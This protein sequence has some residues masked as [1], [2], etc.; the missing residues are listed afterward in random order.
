MASTQ[1]AI[2][3]EWLP[4]ARQ[5]D[6]EAFSVLVEFYL[7]KVY[8][9]CL[10]LL[11]QREDA[12]DCVQETFVKA[13]HSLQ[14]FKSHA[15]FYTWI[16]RIAVNT[17]LDL[18][19][20]NSRKMTLSLDEANENSEVSLRDRIRDERP[21]PDEVLEGKEF[22]DRIRSS[23]A[24]LPEMMQEILVLR[25]LQECSYQEI[26]ALLGIAQGTVKSR[27]YRARR[28]LMNILQDTEQSQ[29]PERQSN[30]V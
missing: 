23:L 15:S 28:Q 26:A 25:D 10:S 27:L 17:C 22:S 19:R 24:V 4:L 7:P 11:G 3:S 16:Y 6:E 8:G 13:W 20:S 29:E 14:H 30:R 12:E 5:G 1:N 9:L 2:E 18:Q 21:L